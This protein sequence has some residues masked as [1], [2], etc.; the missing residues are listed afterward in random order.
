VVINGTTTTGGDGDEEALTFSAEDEQT[1]TK[2]FSKITYVSWSNSDNPS[3]GPGEGS[4]SGTSARIGTTTKGEDIMDEQECGTRVD[5]GWLSLVGVD[6]DNTLKVYVWDNGWG[7]RDQVSSH[8]IYTDEGDTAG[9]VDWDTTWDWSTSPYVNAHDAG[10]FGDGRNIKIE[11]V[12]AYDQYST[13]EQLL[14]EGIPTLNSTLTVSYTLSNLFNDGTNTEV[15]SAFKVRIKSAISAA[16]K[17]TLAAIEA[18]VLAVSGIEGVV[19]DDHST[20]PTIDIGEVH[21]FAWTGSGLLDAGTRSLVSDAVNDT[22]AAGVK[23][24]VQSPI[25][26]YLAVQV[27]VKVDKLSTSSLSTVETNVESAIESFIDGLGINQVVYKTAL[28]EAI[29]ADVDVKYISLDTLVVYGYD[30]DQSTAVSQEAP[31]ASSP[32]WGFAEAADASH[33]LWSSNGNIIFVNS[34]Y[35]LR[36]D[37]EGT[38]TGNEEIKVTA[39]YE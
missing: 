4:A 2:K 3:E 32:Y 16:A 27:T 9:L 34:G 8:Y 24:V 19:V 25:P 10:P 18:A 14:L 36:P 38:G 30:T 13:N 35:V 1:T 11:Y 5:G 37:T 39:E 33:Q 28:I 29:E 17:G 7:I 15:D 20:D 21:V 22:R 31:Y 6:S 26:I 23:P 12:P